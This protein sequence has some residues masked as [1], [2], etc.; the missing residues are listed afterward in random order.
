[1]GD[2][3]VN[4]KIGSEGIVQGVISAVLHQTG[5]FLVFFAVPVQMLAVKRGIRQYVNAAMFS[6]GVIALWKGFQILRLS[7]PYADS[8]LI[9]LDLL[10]PA[11]L[12]VG[13]GCLNFCSFGR[14]SEWQRLSFGTLIAV[15]GI[16]PLL[17][18]ARQSPVLVAIV[19]MQH[20]VFSEQGMMNGVTR[21][22]LLD[23]L[24]T[25]LFRGIGGV[26]AALLAISYYFGSSLAGSR[27]LLQRLV[28]PRYTIGIAAAAVVLIMIGAW[29]PLDLLLWN[30]AA[31][32]GVQYSLSGMALV[33]GALSRRFPGGQGRYLVIGVL[34]LVL[35]VPFVNVVVLVS[36]PVAGIVETV[37]R[38]RE[39]YW[40][41]E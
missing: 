15:I 33:S 23:Q 16:V 20:E 34:L 22:E 21:Q 36:L 39:R 7:A 27:Q 32:L 4:S 24:V 2:Q 1:M 35:F 37:V 17:L 12:F 14:H 10:L 8:V 6:L 38:I 3:Q 25:I 11:S 18:Y 28:I 40:I 31:I 13:L 9:M 30:I 41:K 19:E 29:T 5:I 26:V